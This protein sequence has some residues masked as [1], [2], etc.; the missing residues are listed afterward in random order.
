MM[1]T[2]EWDIA[3][4][5][6]MQTGITRREGQA[7]L[8]QAI[9]NAIN[10]KTSLVAQAPTG[11]GKSFCAAIP[12]I[13]K[14][15]EAKKLGKVF[16]GG[17]STE[18]ITLQNQI[19]GKDLPY[20][21]KLYPGFS[22]KKLMGR[23]NYLCL[24]V[25]HMSAY[26]DNYI[27]SLYQKLLKRKND[28]DA[29]EL[30]DVERV[31]GLEVTDELWSKIQGSQTF[32]VD[33]DCQPEDCFAAQARAVALG[34]DIV[35]V[36]HALL[37]V[38]AELKGRGDV[39]SEGILGT[40]Q[41]M[42]VD[43]AH[44]LEPV[45]VKQWTEELTHWQISNYV[46]SFV[47]TVGR[48]VSIKGKPQMLDTAQKA[49]ED[50]Y[51][52]FENVHNFFEILAAESGEDWKFFEAAVSEKYLPSSIS[53]KLRLA[54]TKYEVVNKKKLAE[55]IPKLE[56][57]SAYMS[58]INSYLQEFAVKIEK[59]R[60]FNK[61]FRS[62]KELISILGMLSKALDSKDGIIDNFGKT[63]VI[64]NG[65]V[66]NDLSHG[67]TIRFVPLDVSKRASDIWKNLGSSV[68]LSATL[69]D[70]TD[71]T[72]NYS[73][74]CV[75]FPNGPE[76]DVASPFDYQT[77]QL[78]YKTLGQGT[79]VEGAQYAMQELVDLIYAVDG[80]S[81]LLFTARKELEYAASVLNTYKEYYKEK[82]P[83]QI[84]VQ[85]QGS[86]KQKLLAEFKEDTRSILLGLKSF[87]VGV[88]VPGEA[89]THVAICK[90]PLAKYDTECKMRM[91]VWRMKKF[92]RWYERES[93]TT[94]AQAAGRLI[95]TTDDHGVISLLD[96]RLSNPEDKTA[97]TAELGIKAL[98]SPVT[99]SIQDVHSFVHQHIQKVPVSV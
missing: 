80:R 17:I 90:F 81:L 60:K 68:L 47:Y 20:L 7:Q 50:I 25:T 41:T 4:G 8:G 55:I 37:G 49:S 45:L 61:G 9:I 5:P 48:C 10:S 91:V 52:I 58:Q 56:H 11:T 71:G 86:N 57:L 75:G 28:L 83:Y 99:H 3:A 92:P 27:E 72:F 97:K 82:F 66:K 16:R 59:R 18:T 89:L 19:A 29:G 42:I 44:A 78:I 1:K 21:Q 94:L 96:F 38:D 13:N 23:N 64:F 93:L 2:P 12:L 88:D 53:H 77:K 87:F 43:E 6:L 22:F 35:V 26:G 76:I 84:L 62:V 15:L 65:W 85:T 63:G 67:M 98:G 31:L 33:N 30:A 69:M 40:L 54:L 24:N 32:C 39:F 95:R 73:R 36:N 14:V 79:K 51:E 70:L 46:D 74:Q 34:A